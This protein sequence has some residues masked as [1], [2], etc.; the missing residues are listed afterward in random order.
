MFARVRG[1]WQRQQCLKQQGGFAARKRILS[2]SVNFKNTGIELRGT[3]PHLLANVPKNMTACRVTH[4][5][6]NPQN[7][8]DTLKPTRIARLLIRSG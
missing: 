8:R 7:D 4:L 2:Y 1:G 6:P 3:S 5:E